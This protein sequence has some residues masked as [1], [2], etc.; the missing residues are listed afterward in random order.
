MG[1]SLAVNEVI[2]IESIR[3]ELDKLMEEKLK[4]LTADKVKAVRHF[5]FFS[6]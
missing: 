4:E 5:F 3:D 6:Q 1:K 2:D